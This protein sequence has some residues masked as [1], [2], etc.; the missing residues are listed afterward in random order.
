MI[1]YFTDVKTKAQR[2]FATHRRTTQ[3]D[4]VA[5]LSVCVGGVC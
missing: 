5:D 3:L 4:G 2:G 1:S